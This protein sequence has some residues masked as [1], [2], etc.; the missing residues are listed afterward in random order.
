MPTYCF[1]TK[2]GT[3]HERYFPVGKCPKRIRVKGKTADRDIAA[4]HSG[5]RSG[6]HGW[7][8]YSDALFATPQAQPE[9]RR[10]LAEKG[11][12]NVEWNKQGQMR[13]DSQAHQRRVMKAL[14][15]HQANCYL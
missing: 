2:D 1:T 12:T 9:W 13:L 3:T 11:V 4:E 10:M 6:G 15:M 14:D 5:Q 8:M 7:P